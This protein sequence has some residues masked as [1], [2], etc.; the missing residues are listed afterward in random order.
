MWNGNQ[1]M[2]ALFI[3]VCCSIVCVKYIPVYNPFGCHIIQCSIMI[4]FVRYCSVVWMETD[5]IYSSS[6]YDQ[7]NQLQIKFCPAIFNEWPNEDPP[8]FPT[9][10]FRMGWFLSIT[11]SYYCTTTVLIVSTNNVSKS[12]DFFK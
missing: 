1:E 7:T 10:T 12:T 8:M 4:Y 5:L 6:L 9:I 11:E 3:E 2:Y